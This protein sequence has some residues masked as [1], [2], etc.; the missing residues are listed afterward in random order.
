MTETDEADTGDADTFDDQRFEW[1]GKDAVQSFGVYPEVEEQPALDQTTD[2][3]H[4]HLDK[5]HSTASISTSRND[6]KQHSV[7]GGP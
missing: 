7:I 4:P 1:I 5:V 6:L 3:R 2:L